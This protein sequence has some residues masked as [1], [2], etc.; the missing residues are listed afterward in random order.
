[1][2]GKTHSSN[3]YNLRS[4]ALKLD[5]QTDV[6]RMTLT[7]DRAPNQVPLETL[8]S[9]PR[10]AELDD[11]RLCKRIEEREMYNAGRG[12][13]YTEWKMQEKGDLITF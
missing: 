9:V 3:R 13:E 6:F 1:M 4:F 11:W 8:R 2:D 12:H 10:P 7:G 5:P